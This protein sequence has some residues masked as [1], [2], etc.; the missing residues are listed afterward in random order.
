MWC[1]MSCI[2]LFLKQ[3]V[4]FAPSRIQRE[5]TGPSERKN[6]CTGREKCSH[7]RTWENKKS[8]RGFARGKGKKYCNYIFIN[9]CDSYVPINLC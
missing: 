3:F 9:K 6:A 7:T 1:N 4:Y 2:F 5:V 8:C